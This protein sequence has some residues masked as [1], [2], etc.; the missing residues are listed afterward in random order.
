[1]RGEQIVIEHAAQ[2]VAPFLLAVP[3]AVLG[4]GEFVRIRAQ[5]VMEAVSARGLLGEEVRARQF[6]QQ[7]TDPDGWAVREC[8]GRVCPDVRPGMQGQEPEQPGRFAG[9][10]AVRPAEHCPHICR[11][12]E[13][14]EG[15]E[16]SVRLHEFRCDA[17]QGE[18]RV[19]QGADRDDGQRQWQ[20]PAEGDDRVDGSRFG[21]HPVGPETSYE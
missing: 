7:G 21:G 19:H 17:G 10:S 20:P 8:G 3:L 4:T 5:E 15:V 13:A 6:G 12:V 9:Q 18:R 14:V 11:R 1:M 2:C 16:A